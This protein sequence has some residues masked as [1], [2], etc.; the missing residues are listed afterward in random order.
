MIFHHEGIVLQKGYERLHCVTLK[1]HTQSQAIFST[2]AGDLTVSCYAP[3]VFRIQICGVPGKPDYGILAT[4]PG[5]YEIE[6]TQIEGG[7]RVQSTT[8]AL[9]IFSNPFRIRFLN[10]EKCLLQ[11]AGARTI[12]GLLRF[13]PFAKGKDSWLIALDLKNEEP[14]YGL[15]EK[16]AALN[17]RGQL[18]HSWNE[19]ATTVNSELSYKNTPFAWSPEGWGLFVH[20][21]SNDYRSS[22]S[23]KLMAPSACSGLA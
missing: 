8:F 18:I 5:E 7:Y 20:T 4:D 22:Q 12:Q 15:G 9:E 11:S 17:R 23:P 21:P 1:S 14:V 6:V 13:S 19:D 16:W 3:G 2:L 10:G